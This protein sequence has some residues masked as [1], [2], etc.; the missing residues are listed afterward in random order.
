VAVKA[1]NDLAG[2]NRI[3]LTLLIFGLYLRITK[4]N[5][6]SPTIVKRA[7]AICAAT[8]EIRRLYTK[9]QVSNA[10]VIR[11]GLNTMATV[12]LSL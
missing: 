11:N 10:L 5:A 4:I 1:V 2:L 3:V 12:D 7:K 6:P 8:K 9:Q